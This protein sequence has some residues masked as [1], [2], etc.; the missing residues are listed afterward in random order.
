MDELVDKEEFKKRKDELLNE[1]KRIKEKINDSEGQAENWLEKIEK[2]FDF[3]STAKERFNNGS[4][5][6][7]RQI[8][9]DLG[10]SFVLKTGGEFLI[11]PQKIWQKFEEMGKKLEN[12][13]KNN[14]GNFELIELAK[15]GSTKEKTTAFSTVISSWQGR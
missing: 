5:E 7:K 9:I 15:L 10:V 11:E 2:T 4:P 6:I 8:A 3:T 12:D 13:L 14:Q 1:Q